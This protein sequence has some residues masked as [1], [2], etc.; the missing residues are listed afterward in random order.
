MKKL[1]SALAAASMI[2]AMTLASA[3]P[4]EAANM[5]QRMRM[6][7]DFCRAH[8]RDNDCN[9]W[10]RRGHG[11]N[12]SNYQ[13]FYHRHQN[14]FPG[15]AAGIFGLAAGAIIAGAVNNAQHTSAS[16]HVRACEARYRSYNPRT[17]T[18][19][20]NNGQRYACNL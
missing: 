13:G 17:D 6:V 15:T 18:F 2:G 8:P 7:D 16:A 14:A 3:A 5:N 9:D 11:W 10:H 19:V 12:N 20:A 4:A 1:I